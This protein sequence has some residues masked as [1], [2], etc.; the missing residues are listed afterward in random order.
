MR[1]RAT[2]VDDL[3]QMVGVS[4]SFGGIHALS[5]FS[6]SVSH[7]EFV[8]LIGPNGAGKTTILNVLCGIYKPD[9]GQILFRGRNIVAKKIHEISKMGMSRT[10]QIVRP[11]SSLTVLENLMVSGIFGRRDGLQGVR[12]KEEC[13]K[14]IAAVDLDGMEEEPAKSLTIGQLRSLEIARALV[15]APKLLL[16]D[17]V[18]AGLNESEVLEKSDLLAKINS[19][20]IT[21]LMVEHN[22]K[23]VMSL[24]KR[25]YVLNEG[26]NLV[27]GEPQQI[28]HDARVIEAYLGSAHGAVSA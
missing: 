15:K 22:M 18:L 16:L 5:D 21:I 10:Y 28:A 24:C 27:E 14:W 19:Y 1:F 12:L 3:L 8:G 9:Q 17:E 13:E 2:E 11:F 7:G 6:L 26:K 23:A 20:D 25:I 4:K